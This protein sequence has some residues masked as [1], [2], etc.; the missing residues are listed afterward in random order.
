MNFFYIAIKIWYNFHGRNI[1]IKIFRCDCGFP[2]SWNQGCWFQF[3]WVS[4][5]KLYHIFS[6]FC[7]SIKYMVSITDNCSSSSVW[8]SG[9]V[10]F[11]LF[12]YVSSSESESHAVS[13]L[14]WLC[15]F[16][17]HSC[18]SMVFSF[19]LYIVTGVLS[20]VI[21]QSCTCIW[22]LPHFAS[23]CWPPW[24]KTLAGPIACHLPF[25][26]VLWPQ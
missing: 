25:C 3:F 22:W 17:W 1:L 5:Y 11:G 14:S 18:V 10:S 4:R 20:K 15:C 16:C 2:E 12:C 24:P 21:L 8:Y 13:Y 19:L 9:F 7:C 6:K 23:T 26:N